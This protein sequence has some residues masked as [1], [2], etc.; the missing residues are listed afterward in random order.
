MPTDYSRV[1]SSNPANPV[2]GHVVTNLTQGKL[3][4]STSGWREGSQIQYLWSPDFNLTGRTNIYVSYHSIW[5]QNQDSIGALEYSV[6]GGA[7]WLPIV[8]MLDGPDVLTATNGT[9]DAFKTFT[10]R[11]TDVATNFIGGLPYGGYYG[12]FIAAPITQ[13]L[14][15]YISARVDDDPVESKRVELF[16]LTAADN[17]PA[18]RFRFAHAGTDSWYFGIDDFGLYSITPG[19]LPV[20]TNA[21]ASFNVS[22]GATAT[23]TVEAGGQPPLNYHWRLN[24]TDIPGATNATF[25]ISSVNSSNQGVYTVIVSNSS[26][27]IESGGAT[28]TVYAPI[29]TG[30]WDFNSGD[31]RA[32]VGADLEYLNDTATITTFQTMLINGQPAR[33]MGFGSNAVRQGYYLRHG[34]KPNCG[35]QFVNQYTLIMDVMYPSQSS[36]QWRALFQTDPFN[37]AGNN[38]DYLVGNIS[39]LPDP[40]GIGANG[41]FNGPLSPDTWYRIAFAVDLAA[42]AGQRLT[43]Y[44][45]GIKVAAQSLEEGVDG[46]YA[47]GPTRAAFHERQRGG[48]FYATGFVNSIQ[49]VNG[50]LSESTIAAL[51]GSSADGI[52]AGDALIH[53]GNIS[54][55]VVT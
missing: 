21:P 10:N 16:R 17:Q 25:V 51:G 4:F 1:L 13:A 53:I 3:V 31:L 27:A 33:V 15:P 54:H 26:G 42:P 20:I 38:A 47:L 55:Q 52:P 49:F 48:R 29:V 40:N 44:V 5:E 36:D 46:R 18:V 8:Y 7:H 35:G 34:A 14:A 50:W 24:G 41:Q 2:N 32:T 43:K 28:L 12:A 11:Y 45:N 6:D 39:A 37:H 22:L 19:A 30:Q 23:F 9:I